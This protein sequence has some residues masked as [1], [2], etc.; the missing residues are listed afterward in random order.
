MNLGNQKKKL[1]KKRKG[2]KKNKTHR[3]KQVGIHLYIHTSK[4]RFRL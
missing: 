1:I 3:N 4:K 2:K